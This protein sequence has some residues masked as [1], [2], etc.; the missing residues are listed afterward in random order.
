MGTP[1]GI[2]GGANLSQPNP[3]RGRLRYLLPPP[4]SRDHALLVFILG[5]VVEGATEGYQF[6]ARA[7]LSQGWLVYY[8]TLAT[9]ILGFYFMFLGAREWASFRPR[10]R[11][12]RAIPWRLI[13]LVA[14]AVMSTAL[15]IGVHSRWVRRRY[16]FAWIL[17][18]AAAA[19]VF[20]VAS[21]AL[22]RPKKAPGPRR[23]PWVVLAMWGGGTAATGILAQLLGTPPLGMA[24]IWVVA[25]VGGLLVLA[26]GNFFLGLRKVV[27]PL[28]PRWSH[29]LGWAAF[30]WSLGVATVAGLVVGERA[31][32]LLVEFGTNWVALIASVAPIVVAMSPLFVTYGLLA[33]AFWLGRR[34]LSSSPNRPIPFADERPR[35]V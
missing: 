22:E 8:G 30:V 6:A 20:V 7:S 5:F 23:I 24:P 4:V 28:G 19:C 2:G 9:T 34:D 17:T 14:N 16:L 18:V 13:A 25:P 3:S 32:I 11:R 12:R 1:P 29:G 26:F 35:S 33:G 31:I 10:I 21:V 15:W 27:H